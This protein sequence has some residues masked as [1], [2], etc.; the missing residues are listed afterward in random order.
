MTLCNWSEKTASPQISGHRYLCQLPNETFSIVDAIFSMFFFLF[1]YCPLLC[2]TLN[3]RF[4][5]TTLRI[6]ADQQH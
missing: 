2:A 6:S 5:G 1:I 3:S 4:I